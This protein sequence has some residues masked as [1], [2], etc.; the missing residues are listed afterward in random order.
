LGSRDQKRN[1]FYNFEVHS[2]RERER[3]RESFTTT[4]QKTEKTKLFKMGSFGVP[5]PAERWSLQGKTALFT[6]GIGYKILS[7]IK[8]L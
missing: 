5:L 6:V 3:E 1:Y 2:C 7:Q 4:R 8:L